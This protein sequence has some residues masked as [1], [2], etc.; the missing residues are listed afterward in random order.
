DEIDDDAPN[1]ETNQAAPESEQAEEGEL[2]EL[3][4]FEPFVLDE[5]DAIEQPSASDA[6]ALELDDF[7]PIS[8][9]LPPAAE[10]AASTS[11][12]TD[13]FLAGLELD[14][15][16]GEARSPDVVAPLEISDEA[17]ACEPI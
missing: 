15:P 7:A 6:P 12:D 8:D 1:I 17:D 2:P 3:A 10:A 11:D 13:E 9:E 5:A 4:A 14:E 16:A